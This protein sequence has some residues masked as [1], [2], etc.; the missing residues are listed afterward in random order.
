MLFSQKKMVELGFESGLYRLKKPASSLYHSYSVRLHYSL[1][2]Q[3]VSSQGHLQG[4][5]PLYLIPMRTRHWV[6]TAEPKSFSV[7]CN[8]PWHINQLN[9]SLHPKRF[10]R[11]FSWLFYVALHVDD[12]R[13][14]GSDKTNLHWAIYSDQRSGSWVWEPAS[15]NQALWRR[16]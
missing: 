14:I 10:E 1:P 9:C 16:Q 3:W 2:T 13:S 12:S 4:S 6:G 5:S 11:N 8:Q 7:H 15:H